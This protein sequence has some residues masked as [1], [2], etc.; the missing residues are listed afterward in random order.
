ML[1]PPRSDDMLASV[2]RF[3]LSVVVLLVGLALAGCS[4]GTPS[5]AS[6]APLAPA[7]SLIYLELTVRPQGAQRA[8]VESALTRLIGHSPDAAIQGFVTRFLMRS[9]L[10]YSDFAPWLGQRIGLVI[11]G[12]SPGAV[13]FIAP[14]SDPA[15]GLEAVRRLELRKGPLHSASYAGVH[16]QVRSTDRVVAFGVVGRNVVVASPSVFRGIVDAY[17][18][19]SLAKTPAFTSA[20]AALPSGALVRG[21]I[22]ATRLGSALQGVLQALPSATTASVAVR[23]AFAAY[24]GKLH[25]TFSFSVSAATRAL[26]LDLHS[27]SHH[28][29][30]ADV[31][32]APAQSWLAIGSASFNPAKVIP[33]LDSLRGNPGFAAVLAK[34]RS[35]LGVDLLRDV[36][37]ALGPFQLSIQ[38]TS[39]L[40]LGAGLKMTPSDPAAAGRLLAAIRRLAARSSSLSVQGS[41]TSFVITK[42]GLPI[43]R[44][45]VALSGGRVLATVDESFSALLSPSSKLASNPRFAAAR[46]ALPPGSRVSAFI[47]VHA[48]T[49]LLSLLPSSVSTLPNSGAL[50]VLKRL[51]YLVVGSDQARG[52][53][54]VVLALN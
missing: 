48:I 45:Q 9:H 53:T 52:D 10:R 22:D 44:V 15:A 26:T 8:A 6:P 42:R 25:G 20:M 33:L 5:A 34:V 27:S 17:H 3:R 23:Q 47:D 2:T 28:G 36:L 41:D 11:N 1:W 46:A 39:L 50:A 54:R 31:S 13:G 40:N 19:H 24:V 32:G 29:L 16:Y 18:G 37:P 43:P 30:A 14:S 35:A 12:F 38:G 51:N 21:Y 4:S 49:Q 7:N